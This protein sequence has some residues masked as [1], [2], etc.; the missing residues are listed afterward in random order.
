MPT[1]RASS[2]P[3]PASRAAALQAYQSYNNIVVPANLMGGLPARISSFANTM[4]TRINSSTGTVGTLGGT[5]EAQVDRALSQVLRQ[6]AL[7]TNTAL[8]VPPGDTSIATLV[9]GGYGAQPTMSPYQATLLREARIT[10]ADIL[11]VLDTLQPLSPYTDPGD[12]ASL[13]AVVRAEVNGLLEEFSYNQLL[14]RRQRVRV[15]LGGLLG[16]N[17]DNSGVKSPLQQSPPAP[18]PPPN[19]VQALVTL[20]NL[21]GPLIPTIAVEDQ[22]ASQQ[23]VGSDAALFDAQW[24]TFWPNAITG[25]N[26]PALPMPAN[27]FFWSLWEPEDLAPALEPNTGGLGSLGPPR[28]GGTVYGIGPQSPQATWQLGLISNPPAPT[29]ESYAEKMIRADLLLPVIAQDAAS[30]ENA[31]TA[32]GY[33]TGEQATDFAWLWSAVD[34]D[35]LTALVPK[36]PNWVL[37]GGGHPARIDLTP[38]PVWM[39]VADILDWAQNLTGA[40]NSDLLRQAG[41]LGLNLLCDQADE[42]FWLVLALLDPTATAQ[43]PALAD[44]EVQLEMFSLATDLSQLAN[45]A[46]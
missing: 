26:P 43:I 17:Y 32:V 25:S 34:A 22:L 46:Y 24:N 38:I 4:Q 3:K 1:N 36:P 18:P 29:P 8:A 27:W 23:V 39:T 11:A 21:G 45:L 30:A 42:L 7:N 20:L 12:V 10:Q 44:S 14:P 9:G 13:Q 40:S 19:D 16:W 41:A 31:L 35:L 33:S 15:F 2:P 37:D 5:L 28:Y 6:P